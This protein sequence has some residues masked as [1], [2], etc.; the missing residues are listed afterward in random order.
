MIP[1]L[2]KKTWK[3]LF[4]NFILLIMVLFS[5]EASAQNKDLVV[6]IARLHIDSVQLENYKSALKEEIEAAILIEP[7]V[8]A[9]NAV[10][11]KNHPTH[12]TIL[13]IYAND[14]A[15]K[16]H[17]QTPHFKKYKNATKDMVKSLELVETD[18]ILLRSRFKN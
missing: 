6:R 18:P 7:G 5:N 12:L 9:L 15:Y 3:Y 10:S 8:L 13:E 16:A 14:D 1:I 11:E 17:L 4:T 2:Q